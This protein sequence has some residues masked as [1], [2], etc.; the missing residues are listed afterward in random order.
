MEQF[1]HVLEPYGVSMQ[2]LDTDN[3][4]QDGYR[5]RFLKDQGTGTPGSYG[6]SPW[7]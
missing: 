1:F 6:K 3:I 2:L 4:E 5:Y 7:K